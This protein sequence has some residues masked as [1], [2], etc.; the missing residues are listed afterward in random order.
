MFIL[1]KTGLRISELCGLTIRDIDLEKLKVREQ[2]KKEMV[3]VDMEYA[4]AI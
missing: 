3:L 2:V 4:K 1:F